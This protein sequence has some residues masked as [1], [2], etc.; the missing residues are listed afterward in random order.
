[1]KWVAVILTALVL[2]GCGGA[3]KVQSSVTVTEYIIKERVVHDTVP[4]MKDTTIY[5]DSVRIEIQYIKDAAGKVT[6]MAFRA[7]CPPSKVKVITETITVEKQK[8]E[9]T[10]WW[11]RLIWPAAFL[12]AIAI[13]VKRLLK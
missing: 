7:E 2:S 9:R 8:K 11:N 10:P 1:M 12:L 3:K 13:L 6:S 4:V 5:K